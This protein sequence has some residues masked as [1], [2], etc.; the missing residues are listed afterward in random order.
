MIQYALYSENHVVRTEYNESGNRNNWCALVLLVN[1]WI[2]KYY[3]AQLAFHH[4]VNWRSS[5]SSLA[6]VVEQVSDASKKIV[7]RS[8]QSD[9]TNPCDPCYDPCATKDPCETENP[10]LP[11]CTRDPCATTDPCATPDPCATTP[12]PCATPD[13]CLP[14]CTPDPCAT[15]CD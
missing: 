4:I 11:I 3:H 2:E 1:E 12:D 13:P 6:P 9:P 15:T 10:C 8:P 7:K 5:A 14:L